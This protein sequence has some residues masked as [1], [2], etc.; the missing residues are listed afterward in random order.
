MTNLLNAITTL[1][2]VNGKNNYLYILLMT[3]L[4]SNNTY[5]Q[6]DNYY[7]DL[8]HEIS[9]GNYLGYLNIIKLN[10]EERK[11]FQKLSSTY[12]LVGNHKKSLETFFSN[13]HFTE[14]VLKENNTFNKENLLYKA[15]NTK[16]LLKQCKNY[17]FVLFNEAH[18]KPQHRI[19]VK[20]KLSKLYELGFRY[21]FVEAL[22]PSEKKINERKYPLI[23]S[24]TYKEPYFGLLLR[25]AL[26]VGFKVFSYENR[27]VNKLTSQERE[28]AM[29]KNIK[30]TLDTLP[31]ARSILLGGYSHIATS[32]PKNKNDFITLGNLLSKDYKVISIDQTTYTEEY[33]T[34]MEKDFYKRFSEK[35]KH[36]KILKINSN[37]WYDYTIVHPRTTYTKHNIANWYFENGNHFCFD[38]KTIKSLNDNES[39]LLQLYIN[40]EYIASGN[41]CLPVFQTIIKKSHNIIKLPKYNIGKIMLIIRNDK[42][43]VIYKKLKH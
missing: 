36:P 8:H 28:N 41:K 19:F 13:I 40:D 24:L 26:V 27:N 20:N 29:F 12:S 21:F 6:I 34:K 42:G 25:E 7:L 32:P 14:E 43:E 1:M 33:E 23:K 22:S 30:K 15:L 16:E 10:I 37:F 5:S 3:I 38:T 4:L 18:H 35:I 31:K 17:D 11:N 39:Y 9:N 2:L